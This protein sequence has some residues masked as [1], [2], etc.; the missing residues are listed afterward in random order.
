M[1]RYLACLTLFAALPLS[2]APTIYPL[3]VTSCNRTVTFAQPPQRAVSH[4]VNLTGMLLALGLRE[5]MVGYSGI[6]GWKTLDPALRKTLAGLPELAPRHA[7]VEN[8]LDVDAD[9]LFAGWSYG[10]HVGG[11]LTPQT[12]APF[13]IP[14][15]EL[16]E[17]CS[18]IM[19]QREASLDDLYRDLDNLGQIFDVQERAQTLVAAMRQ[20]VAAVANRLGTVRQAPRVFLYDSGEDRPTT[21]GRLG[22][23]QALIAAAGGQNIMDD[24]GASWTQIN[25]ESMVERNPQVIV[26]VDYGPTS[27]KHK[28]DFLLD[29][30]ALSSVEAIRQQRFVVLPY[31]AVTPS[32]DNAEAIEQLAAAL[33]PELFA[34]G[35]R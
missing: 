29:H 8:L 25:W 17:S 28:R 34:G 4:D 1:K 23:P 20:R 32:L 18:R 21:S 35:A 24:V 33:H 5:R 19:A 9:F 13:G 22:M 27:W 11:P 26:I 3:E 12:L 14:V 30:P 10:M 7:S 2:A 16:S 15:Y 6:S 31:I